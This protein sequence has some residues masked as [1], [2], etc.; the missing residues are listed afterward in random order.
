LQREE[1]RVR[2]QFKYRKDQV[3]KD[4]VLTKIDPKRTKKL[5]QSKLT[6]IKSR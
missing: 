3:A 6:F 1:K 2:L 5:D 4:E